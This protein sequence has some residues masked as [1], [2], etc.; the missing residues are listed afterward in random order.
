MRTP[1]VTQRRKRRKQV[2][3]QDH[4]RHIYRNIRA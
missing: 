2:V 1:P 3:R 4:L